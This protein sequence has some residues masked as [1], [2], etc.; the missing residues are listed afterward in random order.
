MRRPIWPTVA[1][2]VATTVLAAGSAGAAGQ[3]APGNDN[4]GSAYTLTGFA[5]TGRSTNVGATGQPGEPGGDGVKNTV[6]W[7]WRAPAS[8]QVIFDT[9][10]SA[11]EDAYLC[12][13]YGDSLRTLTNLACDDDAGIG[14]ASAMRASVVKGRVYYIQVDGVR[15]VVG[16]ITARVRYSRC[17]GVTSTVDLSIETEHPSNADDVIAGTEG[18]DEID[19]F[20]GND[21]ICG[22]GGNDLIG[23]GPGDDFVVPGLGNDWVN[24]GTGVDTLSYRD[25]RSANARVSFDLSVKAAQNTMSSGTDKATVFENLEGG[26]G[27]DLLKGNGAANTIWG[28]AGDDEIRGS[29]GDDF[30]DGGPGADRC[31]G[32]PGIDT[33]AACETV[34]GFP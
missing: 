18:P 12:V 8:D 3:R 20:D 14:L 32:G 17:N 25:L 2:T 28:G 10:G 16:A 9:F 19:G 4:F 31:F 15:D 5:A 34:T 11:L 33:W 30:L 22:F 6:W 1:A 7:K 21:T 24:G 26:A 13:F 29:G 27:H 23:A